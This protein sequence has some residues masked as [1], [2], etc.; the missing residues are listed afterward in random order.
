MHEKGIETFLAVAMSRTLG[1]AAELLNVTQ[2]TISYNLSELESEMGMI[3]VDRQKGMKSI[4]MT[5]AGESFLPLALKWQEVSREIGNARN[6]GSAYSLTIGGSES[7]N[8]RLL[9]EIFGL[10]LEHEPP[11]YLRITTDPSDQMYQSVES[12]A[13]DVAITIHEESTRYVQI[14]PFYKEGFLA[15]R[16]PYP[17]ET[18]GEVIRPSEL[19][20][21]MAF[22]IEWSSGFRLWHDHIWDPMKFFKVKL[23]SLSLAVMLMKLPGQWCIIPESAKEQFGRELPQ[24]IFQKL[25]DPPPS[26]VYYKLTHRYPKSSSVP[27]LTI[28]DEVLKQ[29][30]AQYDSEK[31]RERKNEFSPVY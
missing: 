11:V 5:P 17:G 15:A 12:R 2:S 19:N 20:Q 13:L 26:L 24:A 23:D 16:I 22:Y 29:R 30:V 18:P 7:V 27:G 14:E 28:F 25:S 31:E 9:P 21:E 1:K 4:R 8:C 6:P 3:L 10:L